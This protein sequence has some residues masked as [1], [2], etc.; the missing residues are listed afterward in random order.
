M[1]DDSD[2]PIFGF[3]AHADSHMFFTTTAT[4]VDGKYRILWDNELTSPETRFAVVAWFGQREHLWPEWRRHAEAHGGQ[5]LNDRFRAMMALQPLEPWLSAEVNRV[6]DGVTVD[7]MAQ[8]QTR[9][10]LVLRHRFASAA[11]CDRLFDRIMG[12]DPT[13]SPF[14][15][16]AEAWLRGK[17]ALKI[18]LDAIGNGRRVAASATRNRRTRRA[19]RACETVH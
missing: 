13:A 10:V 14:A 4:D 1:T 15:L 19:H 17:T 5:A 3:A 18:R 8:L 12:D 16:V 7:V 11:A 6:G 9:Q 2:R